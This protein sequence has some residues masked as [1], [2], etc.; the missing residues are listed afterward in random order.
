MVKRTKT[1]KRTGITSS[2]KTPRSFS[3]KRPVL[4]PAKKLQL[5]RLATTTSR[6]LLETI[7]NEHSHDLQV[8]EYESERAQRCPQP[9]SIDDGSERSELEERRNHEQPPFEEETPLHDADTVRS[10]VCDVNELETQGEH[11]RGRPDIAEP[12]SATC[13]PESGETR[14][15]QQ[16][17]SDSTDNGVSEEEYPDPV[18]ASLKQKEMRRLARL[19]QVEEYKARELAESREERFRRR[20]S[21]QAFHVKERLAKVQWRTDSLTTV[22]SYSPVNVDGEESSSPT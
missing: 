6:G 17:L 14:L 12:Y 9:A 7:D 4:S 8:C 3:K 10:T 11:N 21:G 16:C 19:K 1:G 13:G 15:A 18:G 22:R 5:K 20:Q 2:S